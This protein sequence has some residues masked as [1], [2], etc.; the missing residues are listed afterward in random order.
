MWVLRIENALHS[1]RLSFQSAGNP[2]RWTYFR[3]LPPHTSSHLTGRAA[4]ERSWRATVQ[5]SCSQ[6]LSLGRNCSDLGAAVALTLTEHRGFLRRCCWFEMN[7]LDCSRISGSTDMVVRRAVR[8][9]AWNC[10]RRGVT[11]PN[12]L[13]RFVVISVVVRC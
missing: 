7:W 3:G 12:L 10:V 5:I 9:L 1:S 4:G 8:E 6:D 13:L 11:P 2:V